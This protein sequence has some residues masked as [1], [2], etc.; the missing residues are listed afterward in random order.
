MEG[1]SAVVKRGHL[2]IKR[3]PRKCW[4][5]LKAWHKRYFVLRDETRLSD[6]RLEMYNGKEPV[7]FGSRR[8]EMTLDLGGCLHVGYSAESTRFPYALVLVCRGKS[9]LLLAAEDELATRSWLLALSLIA[10]KE[11]GKGVSKRLIPRRDVTPDGDHFAETSFPDRACNA[12]RSDATRSRRKVSTC[13]LGDPFRVTVKHTEDSR[14]SGIGGEVLMIVCRHG[15]GLARLGETECF[16][17]WP[18]AYLRQF[19]HQSLA[20][21]WS[22][23]TLVTLEV[24]RRCSTGE[25]VFQFKTQKGR[26]IIEVL[27]KMVELWSSRKATCGRRHSKQELETVTPLKSG[28]SD[29]CIPSV[30]LPDAWQ[31]TCPPDRSSREDLNYIVPVIEHSP[32]LSKRKSSCDVIKGRMLHP[33]SAQEGSTRIGRSLPTT[34]DCLSVRNLGEGDSSDS[35]PE[36]TVT[37]T[38][39]EDEG[40]IEVLP[41]DPH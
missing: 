36:K 13:R 14:K 16:L 41:T 29:P 1:D 4:D 6:P 17:L 15:V 33:L 20:G 26:E 12:W 18:V 31:K 38:E 22:R 10:R 3:P 11:Y 25:G 5:K 39:P 7:S 35:E 28:D 19:R 9:P 32:V 37:K 40:Y 24:G 21:G 2:Y 34:P 27:K 30:S 23:S 8:P